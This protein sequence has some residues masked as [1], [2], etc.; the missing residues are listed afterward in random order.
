MPGDVVHR[1]TAPR[2]VAGRE[3]EHRATLVQ[4]ILRPGEHFLDLWPPHPLPAGE[5]DLP[6]QHVSHVVAGH[7]AYQGGSSQDPQIGFSAVKG[8]RREPHYCC[9]AG[10]NGGESVN[11]K[12]DQKYRVY[13]GLPGCMLEHLIQKLHAGVA[14]RRM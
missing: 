11:E 13:P 1:H 10:E 9:F 4:L 12:E 5:A 3:N 14:P 6:A 2:N 8:Q 7:G